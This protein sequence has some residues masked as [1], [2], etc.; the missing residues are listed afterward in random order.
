MS[1]EHSW[2]DNAGDKQSTQ[3]KTRLNTT[4]TTRKPTWIGVGFNLELQSDRPELTTS[5]M[6][7][8]LTSN[9]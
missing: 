9:S 6:A 1:V 7:W 4:S 5:V 8:P 3:R 2:N